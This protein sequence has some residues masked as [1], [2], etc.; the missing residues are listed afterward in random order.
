MVFM[1]MGAIG[2]IVVFVVI[3]VI[4]VIGVISILTCQSYISK[5]FIRYPHSHLIVISQVTS[6][7]S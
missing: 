4:R 5:V 1:A 6:E 2:A 3:M 7:Q